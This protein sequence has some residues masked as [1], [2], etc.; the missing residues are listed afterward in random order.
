MIPNDIKINELPEQN[1]DLNIKDINPSEKWHL[2]SSYGASSVALKWKN[3]PKSQLLEQKIEIVRTQIKGHLNEKGV[4]NPQDLK[5]NFNRQTVFYKTEDDKLHSF[6]HYDLDETSG[7]IPLMKEVRALSLELFHMTTN[8]ENPSPFIGDPNAKTSA[9]MQYLQE[10][11]KKDPERFFT[12]HH[13]DR[14]FP[15]KIGKDD[16]RL[17]AEQSI[18]TTMRLIET[19]KCKAKETLQTLQTTKITEDLKDGDNKVIKT[20]YQQEQTRLSDIEN[21]NKYIAMLEEINYYSL[22]AAIGVFG[23]DPENI[24][25]DD[26]ASIAKA[27]EVREKTYQT[28]RNHALPEKTWLEMIYDPEDRTHLKKRFP[29]L[30]S[31][32]HEVGGLLLESHKAYHLDQELHPSLPKTPSITGHIARHAMKKIRIQPLEEEHRKIQDHHTRLTEALS[33]YQ[34][35][36]K[37]KKMTV[38]KLEELV[39]DA[40][41]SRMNSEAEPTRKEIEKLNKEIVEIEKEIKEIKTKINEIK[42][43]LTNAQEKLDRAQDIADP[44]KPWNHL[45]HLGLSFSEETHTQL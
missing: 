34:S 45:K 26:H 21:L 30:A 6:S 40:E 28:L 9:E 38:G 3:N 11:L 22:F 18:R 10:T 7:L 41:G 33:Q 25:L 32:A 39:K 5:I 27:N 20:K 23:S 19:L 29:H 12:N 37:D 8:P 17:H 13:F 44:T 14:L 35:A 4:E 36:L 43:P 15:E 24:P 2:R 1:N 16:E 31:D 42:L